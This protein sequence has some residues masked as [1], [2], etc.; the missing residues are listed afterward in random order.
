MTR[1]SCDGWLT[2]LQNGAPKAANQDLREWKTMQPLDFWIFQWNSLDFNGFLTYNIPIWDHLG[3]F[4]SMANPRHLP[5]YIKAMCFRHTDHI[6]TAGVPGI[7]C[8][9]SSLRMQPLLQ[10]GQKPSS[11]L[12]VSSLGAKDHFG[13]Q[14]LPEATRSTSPQMKHHTQHTI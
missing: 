11:S 9:S 5:R 1:H 10:A 12:T 3:L 2:Q 13:A 7:H 6:R 14:K 8:R 4:R